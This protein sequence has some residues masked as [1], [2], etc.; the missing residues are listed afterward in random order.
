VSLLSTAAA[1]VL[2]STH[3]LANNIQDWDCL[4]PTCGN[5]LYEYPLLVHNWDVLKKTENFLIT[6]D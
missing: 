5:D 1:T 3:H 4:V 6:I 2:Y